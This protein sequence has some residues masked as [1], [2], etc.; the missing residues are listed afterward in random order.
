[1]KTC[2][3]CGQSFGC[4]ANIKDKK[5]W[6]MEL[7]VV[8]ALPAQYKDCLCPA[9]LN[10]ISL[11]KNNGDLKEGEDF[12]LEKGLFVFTEKFHLNKG[13]CCGNGCRHC[14]Y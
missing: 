10:E 13:Y 11:K 3:R 7:P 14:P 4:D 12:Y 6:C 8:P 5:C 2:E 1:M 9:C